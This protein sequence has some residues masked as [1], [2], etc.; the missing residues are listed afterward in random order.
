MY[1]LTQLEIQVPGREPD[2]LLVDHSRTLEYLENRNVG[3]GQMLPLL[4]SGKF[5]V[6]TVFKPFAFQCLH[7]RPST[8]VPVGFLDFGSL[9]YK[10]YF[11]AF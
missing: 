6:R 8:E 3:L 10:V 11:G 5:N 2:L 7:N 9:V 4:S 1:R